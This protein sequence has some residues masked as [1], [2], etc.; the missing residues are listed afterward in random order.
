[1]NKAVKRYYDLAYDYHLSATILWMQIIDAP[2]IYNPTIF[3]LRHTAELLLKGLIIN[4]SI[5]LNP[6]IDISLINIQDGAKQRKINEVH[7]LYHLWDNF[8]QLNRSNRIVPC[9]SPNQEQKIDKV[10]RFFNDKDFNSTTFRYP[11]S[12]QGKP[13]II[14]PI[15]LNHSGKAPEL[16]VAPPTIIQCGDNVCVIKKGIRYIS[17]TQKLF[18]VIELLFQFYGE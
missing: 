3:L 14:E 7:S 12:K 16:G 6:T 10:I 2:Y 18:D 4:E 5:F 1:M 15:D 13:I 17:Q 11:F 9:Y 8:K